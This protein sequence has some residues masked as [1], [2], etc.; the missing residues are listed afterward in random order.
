MDIKKI[1]NNFI[2]KKYISNKMSLIMPVEN[3]ME[4]NHLIIFHNNLSYFIEIN[5]AKKHSNQCIEILGKIQGYLLVADKKKYNEYFDKFI[6]LKFFELFK[7]LLEIKIK[8]ISYGILKTICFLTLNLENENFIKE[9]YS[10]KIIENVISIKFNYDDE[11]NEFLINFMKSLTLKLNKDNISYFYNY[12][13]NDFPLLTIALS[14]YNSNNGMIRNVVRNIILQIIKIDEPHL[15][16]FLTA[17]PFCIYYPQLIF[18]LREVIYT[19]SNINFDKK[20]INLF[21]NTHDDLIDLIFYISDLMSLNIESINFILI[22]TLYNDIIFPIIKCLISNKNEIVSS[23]NSI[24]ILTLILYSTKNNLILNSLCFFLF[25]ELID[26]NIIEIIE[27]SNDFGIYPEYIISSINFMIRNSEIA[28]VNDINWKNISE[29]M[30]IKTG[31]N[32]ADGKKEE[33]NVF[34]LINDYL[35]NIKEKKF[36]NFCQNDIVKNIKSFCF[37]N[38]DNFILIINLIIYIIFDNYEKKN[39]NN[40]KNNKEENKENIFNPLIICDFFNNSNNNFSFFNTLSSL[41][42]ETNSIRLITNEIILTNIKN[43][44]SFLKSNINEEKEIIKSDYLQILIDKTIK[45]IE[46]FKIEIINK[47]QSR[48]LLYEYGKESY[49]IYIKKKDKKINDLITLPW[50]LIPNIY[51]EKISEYPIYLYPN[52]N[53][54]DILNQFIKIFYLFDIINFIKKK[55]EEEIINKKE[56]P[57]K[58]E[59][60]IYTLGKEYEYKGILDD[61]ACCEYIIDPEKN[62]NNKKNCYII[63]TN[64]TFYLAEYNDGNSKLPSFKV[65]IIKKIPLRRLIIKFYKGNDS[66]LSISEFETKKILIINCYEKKNT[67]NVMNFLTQ[68]KTNAIQLEFLLII[69]FLDDLVLKI[70]Q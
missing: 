29:F 45:I 57:V 9:I 28:D 70:N 33:N 67:L 35:N 7:I 32:L 31:I 69:S 48:N 58:I 8:D 24:Y 66:L 26:K 3:K 27:K 16:N 34:D 14:Y 44:I 10:S 65:K 55:E 62:Q 68:N 60:N 18:K 25:N 47:E 49:E 41:I 61:K 46:T 64:D 59:S 15:R 17:F 52:K 2:L 22:N 23:L 11:L 50:I 37:S 5:F 4:V 42:T 20:K 54:F 1:K 56:F 39:E 40:N 13:I 53:K 38:D 63:I 51:Y 43:Y 30:K 36:D 21:Q 19:I 12:E 6:E